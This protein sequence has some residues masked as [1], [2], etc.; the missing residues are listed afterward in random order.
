MVVFSVMDQDARSTSKNGGG[1]KPILRNEAIGVP[2]GDDLRDFFSK[3]KTGCKWC[4]LRQ[5][6][7]FFFFIFFF[8]IKA[9]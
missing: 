7:R 4:I 9:P 5:R 2:D 1:Y 3:K 6:V 8:A